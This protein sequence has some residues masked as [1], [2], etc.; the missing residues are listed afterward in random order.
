MPPLWPD[1]LVKPSSVDA[2]IKTISEFTGAQIPLS[3]KVA[4]VNYSILFGT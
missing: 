4:S 2:V 3:R 1:R